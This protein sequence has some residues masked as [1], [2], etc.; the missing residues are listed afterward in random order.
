MNK[1]NQVRQLKILFSLLMFGI[2]NIFLLS[3]KDE[4]KLI[5]YKTVNNWILFNIHSTIEILT[6][7]Y[8]TFSC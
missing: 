2:L 6:G 7:N 5:V 4:K 8:L 1:N 3:I